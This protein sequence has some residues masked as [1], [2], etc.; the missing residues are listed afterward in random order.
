MA[1]GYA[2]AM[3]TAGGQDV[4]LDDG[5]AVVG[6]GQDSGRDQTGHT[7]PNNNGVA[8]RAPPGW[9]L[10][11]IMRRFDAQSTGRKLLG[12]RCAAAL[13]GYTSSCHDWLI[14]RTTGG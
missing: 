5:D 9:Q 1:L 3:L 14:T 12:S 11:L 13:S 8:H 4:P 7:G 6:L 2:A 10:G